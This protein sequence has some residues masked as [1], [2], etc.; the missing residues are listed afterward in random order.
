[1]T[2]ERNIEGISYTLKRNRGQKNLRLHLSPEGHVIV[3]APYHASFRE[4]DS[5]VLSSSSWI[6][7]HAG[8]VSSHYYGTGDF[9]PFLGRKLTLM[10]V[11]G[12]TARYDIIDDKIIVTSKN[13]DIK[14]IRQTIKQLYIDT[15]EKILVDR[16]PHWCNAIGVP[17][18][19]FGVN[20][21]K[22]KWG[23]CYPQKKRLYLSYMCATLPEELIDMTVLHEVCHLRHAGHGKD[24]WNLMK[25]HMPDLYKRKAGLK[26]LTKSG[27]V[28]NTV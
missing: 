28:M 19:G 27:W 15:I 10:V 14:K 2:T 6:S 25:T 13:Q 26:E 17:V 18:P 20:R 5:F 9:V 21:A 16:V 23:V 11:D 3:T 4:T 7:E 1:M 12:K 22:G 24:F 8:K